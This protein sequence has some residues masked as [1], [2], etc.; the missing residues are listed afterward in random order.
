VRAALVTLALAALAACEVTAPGR[1]DA[2]AFRSSPDSLVFRWSP[3]ELPVHFHA[4]P[5]G[6]LPGWVDAALALWQ[7]QFLYGEFRAERTDDSAGAMV[8]VE[9]EGSAPPPA[10]VTGA[11]P[12]PACEGRTSI[13]A[14]ADNRLS[15]PVLIRLRWFAPFAPEQIANCLAAVTAHEVGHALGL[16]QH[17]DDAGDLMHG[18]PFGFP[19]VSAPSARDRATVQRLYHTPRDIHP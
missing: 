7:D 3:D 12:V 11:P 14:G 4:Q 1:G 2:Y 18:L 17:S 19:Q 6:G 10:V 9:L 8:R 13:P 16:L 15:G 5:V